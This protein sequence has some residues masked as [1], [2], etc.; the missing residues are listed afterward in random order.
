MDENQLKKGWLFTRIRGIRD[1]EE[2]GTYF[3]FDYNK[4]PP[5]QI[6]LDDAF[7]WMKPYP[8]WVSDNDKEYDFKDQLVSLNKEAENKG[9]IIPNSFNVFLND[10]ELIR[11]I[12]S[13]TDCYFE[14]GDT[15]EEIPNTNGL[16]FIHFLSDSQ[17]CGFWYLCLDKNGNNFVV[18]SGNLYGHTEEGYEMF[19]ENDAEIGYICSSNFKEFIFRFWIENEI[20]YKAVYNKEAL[21]KIEKNYADFYRKENER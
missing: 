17:Y 1:V 8:E 6:E 4:L 14:L 19:R 9:L 21:N 15:I 3:L 12:R 7:N 5:I 18:T 16:H 10:I 20:C 2:S 13:N 11:R